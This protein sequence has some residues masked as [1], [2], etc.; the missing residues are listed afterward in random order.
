MKKTI[1][2]AALLLIFCFG[3]FPAFAETQTTVL[4]YMCGTDIQEDACW[5]IYEMALAETGDNINLVLLAGGTRRWEFDELKGGRCTLAVISDGDF[6]YLEDWGKE[7]MGSAET[8][9]TFLCAGLSEFPADRTVVILWDHGSGSEGGICFDEI[10][11]DDGLTL[12][13]IDEALSTAR[14]AL[15]DF[16]IDIFGCDACMMATYEMAAML[17]HYDIDYFIASEELEAGSGWDY[18]AW[19][20]ELDRNPGI[21]GEA[22]CGVIADSYMKAALEE[23]PDDYL[24]MSAVSLPKI[25]TLEYSMEDFAEALKQEAQ[26]GN[27]SAIRRARSRMYTF[28]AYYDGS[29][30]MVDM[31]AALDAYAQFAPEK[32]A[33]A[34]RQLDQAVVVNRQTRNLPSCSGLALFIPQ[35]TADEFSEY[36]DGM[37]ISAYIPNWMTFV[38]AYAQALGGGQYSFTASAPE[39]VSTGTTLIGS[40]MSSFG[41]SGA[42]NWNQQTESY[43]TAE[44]ETQTE[45]SVSDGEFGFT[46]SLTAKDME[47]LDY[48]EGMLMMDISDEE[49]FGYVDFGLMQ[50]NWIDWKTGTVYSKFD[51]TWPVLDGQLVPLYDQSVNELSRRSLIP[52]RLNGEYTYLVVVFSGGSTEGRI[53]GANAGYDDNGLPIRKTTKLKD[54]DVIVP[55]YTLYYGDPED[56]GDDMEEAE[57]E[58]DE[59]I[60][61][62]GM[63][64]TYEDISDPDDPIDAM[65]CFVFND[66]FGD[67]TMSDIISFS[68]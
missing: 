51:G 55:V 62:E 46:A 28:G 10:Y 25:R 61:R 7:S 18:T 20:S 3:L 47:Y 63:T 15:G 33:K 11:D 45:I 56:E 13:E 6:A 54:G 30:D 59:I 50:N 9:A 36:S 32:A 29:W 27:I 44:E 31:G 16:H 64:V 39:Q 53:V 12:R 8:L 2:S 19:L 24:T 42:Y 23:D 1:L 5:D 21:S 17:S 37:D 34:R 52:V 38:N 41:L 14:E 65:F 40:L 4:I 49:I 66:I 48:V 57:F 60:W 35:D 67:Y 22:L 26:S 58:G 43:E 68:I